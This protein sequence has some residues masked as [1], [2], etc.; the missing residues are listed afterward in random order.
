MTQ[1]TIDPQAVLAATITSWARDGWRVESVIGST[2]I[3][4][5]GHR[6]RQGGHFVMTVLT[7]GLWLAVW[8]VADVAGRVRR[9]QI[10]VDPTGRVEV[11]TLSGRFS[12]WWRRP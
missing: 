10:S 11:I 9:V 7:L 6:A 2:A 12:P 8:I 3:L 4:A 1:P 5:K